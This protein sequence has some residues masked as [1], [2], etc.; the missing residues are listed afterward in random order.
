M[1]FMFESRW[2]FRPTRFALQS[3]LRQPDYDACWANFAKADLP[4]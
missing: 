4:K 2:D 3:A 1:A